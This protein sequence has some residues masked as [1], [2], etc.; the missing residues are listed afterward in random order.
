[1]ADLALEKSAIPRH[2]SRILSGLF[3]PRPIADARVAILI[4]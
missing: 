2:F 3:Q 1:M 4:D